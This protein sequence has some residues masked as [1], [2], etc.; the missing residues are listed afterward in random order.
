MIEKLT[1][2]IQPIIEEYGAFGVLL[3][4]LLEEI[5]A[6]IPSPLVPLT[7]GFFLLPVDGSFLKIIWQ[8]LFIIAFPV[9]F[10]ITLG[11]L[12]VYGL[13]W[14]GGKPIIERSKKWIGLS[15]KD[16][17]KTERK[18]IRG[19]SDEITLFILRTLPIIPGVA[20]SGFC[21]IVRYPLKTF[22]AITFLGA[23]V[24]ATALGVAGWYAGVAYT[25][26]AETISKIENYIF[27]I[28]I[29]SVLFFAGRLYFSKKPKYNKT[30]S[31]EGKKKFEKLVR[32]AIN[33]LSARMNKPLDNLAFVIED[34]PRRKRAG[35]MGI[36]K[37]EVLLGLYEGIPK[38]KRDSGYFAV[39]PDKITIFQKTIEE[40]SGGSEEK[41]KKIISETV[42]HEVGHH[43]GFDEKEIR[44][45]EARRSRK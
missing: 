9:A 16:L 19:K 29:V 2:Y 25:T 40:L 32:E 21:G 15:W 22:A 20:I 24:R 38:T 44:A 37:G 35:E 27:A 41:L 43:L 4:T 5:V 12:A 1:S 36:R 13:G 18:L 11:S 42:W 34:K 14:W 10:G 26:Y 28:L 6:P 30:T 17:E 8:A 3:A 45:L 39:L 7:A 31:M 23:L 33:T